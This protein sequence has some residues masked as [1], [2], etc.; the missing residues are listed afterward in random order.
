LFELAELVLDSSPRG[1]TA[2]RTLFENLKQIN[3]T[4]AIDDRTIHTAR[5]KKAKL[6]EY[7]TDTAGV[8]P[9]FAE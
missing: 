1:N 5:R 7:C 2:L 8:G 9:H 6:A 3:P 4:A